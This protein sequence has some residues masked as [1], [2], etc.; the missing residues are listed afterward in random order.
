V[1]PTEHI[2]S[3]TSMPKTGLFATL[4]GLL[5][6]GGS[7]ASSRA[8]YV[9]TLTT[10][11][12]VAATL[13]LCTAYAQAADFHDFL[14]APSVEITKG[15]P[16]GA[17]AAGGEAAVTGSIGG[18]GAMTVAPGEA[19][20]EA[21]H[22]WVA[23]HERVDEFNAS[24]GQWELQLEHL[25][26]SNPGYNDDNETSIAAGSLMGERE[27][28]VADGANVA[29]FGP[30]GT[31]Q[32]KWSGAGTP[33]GSFAYGGGDNGDEPAYVESVAVDSSTDMTDWAK[34]DVFVSTNIIE[35][36]K[37]IVVD[38]VKPEKEGKEKYVTQL[39]GTCPVEGAI[40]GAATC[41]GAEIVPFTRG[42]DG[43]PSMVVDPATGDLLVADGY[44]VDV[45]EPVGLG[46]YRYL[47]KIVGVPDHTFGKPLGSVTA[48]G[49]E[50]DG[51]I[52]VSERESHTRGVVVYQ[53]SSAG[54]YEGSL[55]GTPAGPFSRTEAVAVDPVSG[56]LYVGDSSKMDVFGPNVVIPDVATGS[57][58]EVTPSSGVLNGT[59]NPLK[60]GRASCQF[61]WGTSESLGRTAEC[62]PKEVAEGSTPAQVHSEA[63]EHLQ[64]DS[65]YY[66][67][68]QATNKNGTNTGVGF[69][70]LTCEGRRSAAACFT[71]VGPGIESETVSDVAATSATFNAEIDP[72]GGPTSYYFEYGPTTAYDSTVPG[73]AIGSGNSTAAVSQH[74]Q[75]GLAAGTVY[76]YRVV[77]V[78]EV[79]SEVDHK[80]ETRVETFYGSDQTF[81]TQGPGEFALPDGREWEMVS[82]PQKEGALIEPY[83]ESGEITQAAANGDA[84]TYLTNVPTE[85]GVLGYTNEQQ[86]LSRRGPDGWVTGDL[87]DGHNR[88]TGQSVEAGEEYRF[89]SEDLSQGVVQPFGSFLPCR[90]A[91]GAPQPCLSVDASEQ[92][93]FLHTNFL[94]DNV[95][96]PCTS[97]CFSPLVTGCPPEGQECAP[98]VREHANVPAGTVFGKEGMGGAGGGD[99][100]GR[101]VDGSSVAKFCGPYFDGA[102]S[103]LSH[104]VFNGPDGMEEWSAGAPPSEQLQPLA[105]L[106]PNEHGEELPVEHEPWLGSGGH[107]AEAGPG[108]DEQHAISNDGSRVFWTTGGEER[109]ELYMREDAD[110]PPR[111]APVGRCTATG[112]A[113]TIQ[114]GGKGAKFEDANAEGSRVFFGEGAFGNHLEG[115]N[116]DVCEITEKAGGL[117]C[118]TTD[119]G[120]GRLVG[121]SE[122][123]SYVYFE[124]ERRLELRHYDSEPGHEEWE[125][126]RFIA[127]GIEGSGV[128]VGTTSRVSP[129][130]QWLVFVS[131]RDLTGYDTQDAVSG[132]LDQEVYLYDARTG[133][134]ACASCDPTGARPI[135]A[136]IENVPILDGERGRG[137]EDAWFA[138]ALPMSVEFYQGTG[139]Y[140]P[141]YLSNSGRLFFDSEDALV[142]Q[143]VNGTLDVYEYEP[144]GVGS[145]AARCG[146]AAESGSDVFKPAH[147]FE[148]EGVKGEEGAGCVGLIS[149][150]GSAQE[151]A[152]VDASETGGDVF[153]M[154]TSRLAPQDFDTAYDIYD[155]HECTS[156]S[157]CIPPPPVAPPECTTADACRAAPTPEPSIYGAPSSQTFSGL[158]DLTPTPA[159]PAVLKKKAK[160]AVVCKKSFVKKHG[161][162]ARAKAGKKKAKAGKSNR[163]RRAG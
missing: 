102:T 158:G 22:L 159:T 91:E 136:E 122:D 121:A 14:L 86:V 112:G 63:L 34:G 126:P 129:D 94:N 133:G 35:P 27:V 163:D 54:V 11:A 131:K 140:Q 137:N 103:D 161:K 107:S 64:P 33:Q 74:V 111:P 155:A 21:D 135:G 49:G 42:E 12:T 2:A 124:S 57:A 153:F 6:A 10:L 31:L 60:E 100:C 154:T 146:P 97:S 77:A 149:S 28:Y 37:G 23:E 106:P 24:T 152:L 127:S 138:A 15:A 90:S 96:E 32:T 145:E 30:S 82:P 40:V 125:A 120:A 7:G 88:A 85:S 128:T 162:C 71:T 101:S 99:P 160:K 46:E 156:A 76:H 16:V 89:F 50:G 104:V 25:S 55:T 29:V 13:A 123:G 58:S 1:K 66:Y 72:N 115:G 142:P 114:I 141:R 110:R 92:T 143:D 38:V 26:K 79:S 105:L 44:V 56:D 67:R 134:L 84:M 144:E 18:S 108:R 48:G 39:T 52:Y 3:P 41:E 113:C 70:A 17:K 5:H 118:E 4:Y 81:K 117:E 51:D 47:R 8:R 151:S 130:G 69:Q 139:V 19:L 80:R 87:A 73:E 95:D 53:F 65:T 20:G 147:A 61:E 59:V 75:Q 83:Q 45:F 132:E 116:L 36:G 68:L 43:I 148:M 93:A 78:S 150:G 9:L 109:E 157:P 98:G 62:E 119:L